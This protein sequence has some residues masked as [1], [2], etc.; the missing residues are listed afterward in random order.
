MNIFLVLLIFCDVATLESLNVLRMFVTCSVT[1]RVFGTNKLVR[2]SHV[3]CLFRH[4]VEL[5]EKQKYPGYYSTQNSMQLFVSDTPLSQ[6][7]S[8]IAFTCFTLHLIFL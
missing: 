1:S 8:K 2:F 4:L 3:I 6:K 7:L 5:L